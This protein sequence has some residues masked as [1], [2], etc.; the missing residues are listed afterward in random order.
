MNQWHQLDKVG[1]HWWTT[2]E[3]TTRANLSHAT[4]PT[5]LHFLWLSS[6]WKKSLGSA[7]AMEISEPRLISLGLFP[8]TPGALSGWLKNGIFSLKDWLD[9]R[10]RLPYTKV[11]TIHRRGHHALLPPLL[12]WKWLGTEGFLACGPRTPL[13]P[14]LCLFCLEVH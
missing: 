10:G 11:Q 13:G 4:S 9:Q 5:C 8:P 14:F 2:R 6:S 7:E 1:P 12:P 3:P